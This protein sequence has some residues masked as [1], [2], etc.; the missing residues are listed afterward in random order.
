MADIFIS[1]SRKDN[2]FVTRL[3][4]AL[5]AAGRE[6]WL[7]VKNIPP[8][9]EWMAEISLSIESA[10]DF[11]FVISPDS[12][13]SEICA[14]ELDHAI[15]HN[16][17]LVPIVW[18]EPA[19]EK[20]RPELSKLNWIFFRSEDSFE[21]AFTTLQTALDT[22]LD[23][24][25][26]HT[27]LLVRAREW[28]TRGH[29]SSL[30]LRGEDLSEAET[31]LT[32]GTEKEPHPTP[33]QVEYIS[34]SRQAERTRQRRTLSAVVVALIVTAALAIAAVWQT[35]LATTREH[36]R[37]T[38]QAI[39]EEQ[40]KVAEEQ[41]RVAEQETRIALSGKLA[42]QSRLLSDEQ[43]DL[44][45]L[46]A[47]L[48]RQI[49]PT[50]EAISG[51]HDALEHRPDLVQYLHGMP[52]GVTWILFSPDGD[53]LSAFGA[54]G[55]MG[56]WT[57]GSGQAMSEP[58]ASANY[59]VLDASLGPQGEVR[60]V[61]LDEGRVFV[62]DAST[63]KALGPAIPFDTQGVLPHIAALSPD[64]A[65]LATAVQEEIELWDVGSGKLIGV[66]DIQLGFP[67]SALEFS[68]DGNLLAS[69]GNE[70]LIYF[71]DPHSGVNR[72]SWE[73]GQNR[74]ITTLAF[75]PDGR[76]IASGSEEGTVILFDLST[77]ERRLPQPGYDVTTGQEI[78][79]PAL[80]HPATVL[81]L[82][83]S[84]N[85]EKLISGAEDGNLLVWDTESMT[86]S[87][88]PRPAYV[89]AILSLAY[90]PGDDVFAAAGE[91]GN[92]TLWQPDV[93]WRLER[94]KQ[95]AD[96][97]KTF[98][99]DNG[100]RLEELNIED[101]PPSSPIQEKLRATHVESGVSAV[102]GCAIHVEFDYEECPPEQLVIA[103]HEADGTPIDLQP[104]DIAL[105]P[106]ALIFNSDA[107]MLA[108]AACQVRP[109]FECGESHIWVWSLPGG[110]MRELV[111]PSVLVN[112][113]IFSQDG[114]Y[115]AA[116]GLGRHVTLFDL[117][118][119]A[120]TRLPM[121]SFTGDLNG[122]TFSP[123]GS[124]LVA[125]ASFEDPG[126]Y[127]NSIQHNRLF[128]WDTASGQ[129]L[130]HASFIEP[131]STAI[132]VYF[133]EDGQLVTFEIDAS[134]APFRIWTLAP[135][136][137]QKLACRIANRE[138]T[139]SEWQRYVIGEEYR[140]ICQ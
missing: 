82:V 68:P 137:W 77:G 80:G 4:E 38:Q 63:G 104:A 60:I 109:G 19:G 62:S 42:T 65:I 74:N 13:R 10:D 53:E 33:L 11:V 121:I 56:R 91:N 18:R 126:P 129:V 70:R 95:E 107:T 39:A 134:E 41:R 136:Q 103:A 59:T 94:V 2:E 86:P 78:P 27:R 100:T 120:E 47:V 26:L 7:D 43:L 83:F 110:E 8:N 30:T 133:S 72:A 21:Q 5:K 64:G 101:S 40:R 20:A 23:H 115:L 36:A 117:E 55:A 116:G 84:P 122:L 9:A 81:S 127:A 61:G 98:V 112:R 17:R 85:G 1:Y 50:I 57:V 66:S 69:A 58:V 114:R 45:L 106:T 87:S 12:L 90:H 46:L 113:L 119:G 99:Y 108:A 93:T 22:D 105:W 102:G 124:R 89:G 54:N 123:D 125:S 111:V 32:Q 29:S 76:F 138:I 131:V 118:S 51:L 3:F 97:E 35:Q 25:R 67:P 130:A 140:P 6:V 132:N 14:R 44:A 139:E 79:P 34:V 75:S 37:A 52:P 49:D 28:E 128:E 71:W 15:A 88:T 92:I 96:M 31:W 73:T 16:K 48:A 135:D 24:V